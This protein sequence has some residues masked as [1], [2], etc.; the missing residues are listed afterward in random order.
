MMIYSGVAGL[1]TKWT[2]AMRDFSEV[3]RRYSPTARE[4]ARANVVSRVGRYPTAAE[5]GPLPDPDDVWAC[6]WPMTNVRAVRQSDGRSLGEY[7][8]C[9][10]PEAIRVPTAE[11][12]RCTHADVLELIGEIGAVTPRF[13]VLTYRLRYLPDACTAEYA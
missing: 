12:V 4:A 10:L 13:G 9:E 8:R 5:M 1:V 3:L 7:R 2:R 6:P 11:D